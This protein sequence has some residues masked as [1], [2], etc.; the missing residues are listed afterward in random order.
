M[1]EQIQTSDIK[2]TVREIVNSTPVLD[3]H[4]H[5]FPPAFGDLSLWGIDQILTYHYLVAEVF[6]YPGVT[7][8]QF[9]SASI[10]EQADWIWDQLFVERSPLSE[11]CRGVI[12]TL[13]SLGLDAHQ[14]DLKS[15]RG[16]F[17]EQE[18]NQFLDR[19]MELAGVSHI[20]MTNSPFDE[21]ERS[22]WENGVEVDNRFIAALRLDPLLLDWINASQQLRDLGYDVETDLRMLS[23]REGT[24][25]EVRRFLNEWADKIN[26]KYVMVSLPPDFQFPSEEPSS[27]LLIEAV[28]P[29]CEARNL[30]FAMMMGVRRQVNPQ[31]RLAGD[32]VERSDLTP[33]RHFC[34]RHPK[35][36]FMVTALSQGNQQE[37]CVLTSK[38]A[39]LHVFGCWW[40]M[41]TPSLMEDMTRMRLELLGPS[42]TM[43]H[44]DARII[45]QLIYK[46]KHTREVL[47]KVLL[48]KYADLGKAGWT[49]QRA[50]I[51]RDVQ[52]LLGGA[53]ME[54]CRADEPAS[55]DDAVPYGVRNL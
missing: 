43:Q 10:T 32:G 52:A 25:N 20:G 26:A 41:N 34:E 31:L 28:L 13:N 21:T 55:G 46:W 9:W 11:A 12:T 50:E 45:D 33:L 5:L 54:F 40:F 6:Q 39:N 7:Y 17:A 36:K 24:V 38:F 51:E 29:F 27:H 42:F 18:P 14:K 30:P 3:I 4:T 48:D 35:N 53:F 22:F 23:V 16:W 19:C 2:N 8:D 44:S 15:L 1:T 47:I 37:L 49:P